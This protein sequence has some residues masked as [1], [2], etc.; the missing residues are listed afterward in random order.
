[1]SPFG[2]L[3]AQQA[4]NPLTGNQDKLANLK[5]LYPNHNIVSDGNDK[6]SA[7]DK[8]GHLIGQ[9]LS[10]EDMCKVLSKAKPEEKVKVKVDDN[11]D[12]NDDNKI[13]DDNH[14]GKVNDSNVNDNNDKFGTVATADDF[15]KYNGAFT[16]H[17]EERGAIGDI[18]RDSFKVSS[19]KD[20]IRLP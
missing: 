4:Q 18:N 19:E 14:Q 12:N 13:K 1:M 15:G 5:T 9:G 10:Y 16:V 20:K 6:Y 3:N 8:D 7:T 2:A 11:D 17:D